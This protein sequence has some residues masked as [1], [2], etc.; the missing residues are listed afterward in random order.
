MSGKS[1]TYS[2]I[3]K[4]VPFERKEKDGQ[5]NPKYVDLLEVDKPIAGQNFGCFSFISPEK[6]LKQR[7]MFFFEEFLKK[8]EMNKSMEKFHQF[9]NFVS[10]KYKL[11]FEE[12]M[13]DF[14]GFVKEERETIVSSSIEDDYKTFLDKEE[15]EL[16]NK[17]NVKYNF[18]TS[19]RGFKARGNFASQEEA[20][21]RAKLLRETDPSFD[22]FVGP[23]GT[24]L[25][26]EPEAYKTGRVEYMEEELNQLAQEKKKN[27]S[28]AK[29]AFEQRV[30]ETKQK[31]ID[32]NKKNAEKYGNT[33]TQD[34]DEEGNLIGVAHNT[35]ENTF[36]NKE[37]EAI[38]VADIR[39][40]LFDGD[41]VVTGKTDYGQSLLKSGPFATNKDS[42]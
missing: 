24:W 16:E 2:K 39:S 9:L 7:E 21:L 6:T 18:Q 41:N 36:S 23:I 26:W 10:Y 19:V 14:E 40:E 34:I 27:E 5:V 38:S 30:K 3:A 33:I 32:D 25:P 22:V 35:T 42:T 15:E 20:E 1:K 17:F 4:K 28:A 29:T 37:P 13:K 31:A 12:V 8:W 11:Q